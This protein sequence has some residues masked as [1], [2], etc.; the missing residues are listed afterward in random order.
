MFPVQQP[1]SSFWSI[2]SGQFFFGYCKWI[3]LRK[4]GMQA[5]ISRTTLYSLILQLPALKA[6]PVQFVTEDHTI[7]QGG[8]IQHISTYRRGNII[9][10]NS[11]ESPKILVGTSILPLVV[12]LEIFYGLVT[13]ISSL[14]TICVPEYYLQDVTGAI[15]QGV[16]LAFPYLK[17]LDATCVPD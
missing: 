8:R 13:N 6:L 2:T 15:K 14:T 5:F 17:R 7:P 11:S 9:L 1:I 10:R 4:P 16:M 12:S 3:W